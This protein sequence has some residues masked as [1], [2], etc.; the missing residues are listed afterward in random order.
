MYK[1]IITLNMK[2]S[3]T[4]IPIDNIAYVEYDK[5][6]KQTTVYLKQSTANPRFTGP[7][8]EETYGEIV[9]II[10]SYISDKE[11]TNK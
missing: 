3:K 10:D 4:D 1:H 9:K 11:E 5:D 6:T 7:G 2:N 8:S